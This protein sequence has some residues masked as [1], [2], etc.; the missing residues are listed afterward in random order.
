M[1]RQH[2]REAGEIAT[3]CLNASFNATA[4]VVRPRHYIS[5][6]FFVSVLSLFLATGETLQIGKSYIVI[7][8]RRFL[9]PSF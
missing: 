8:I 7:M 9:V 2:S 6:T 4:W 3:Y 5:G 1:C